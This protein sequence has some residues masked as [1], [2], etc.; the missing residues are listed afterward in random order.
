MNCYHIVKDE[1]YF[2]Q[3]ICYNFTLQEVVVA[4]EYEL[5]LAFLFSL[6]RFYH[7]LWTIYNENSWILLR[8]FEIRGIISQA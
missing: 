1:P 6:E 3:Y 5:Q 4:L 2:V 7:V 8:G